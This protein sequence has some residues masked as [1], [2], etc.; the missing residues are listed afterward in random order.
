MN[1][2]ELKEHVALLPYE[3]AVAAITV[4]LN[5]HPDSTDAL[6]LRGM[7]HF[8]AGKRALA[9]N[10]YHAALA[11][12]PDCKARLALQSAN[13]ILDFYNKDLFNP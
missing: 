9:I 10:D 13:D 2:E 11:I 3:E 8:G 12:D 1:F 7:K 4:Y 6:T 5:E